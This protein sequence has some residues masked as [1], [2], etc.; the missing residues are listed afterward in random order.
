MGTSLYAGEQLVASGKSVV[1]AGRASSRLDC[2]AVL[3]WSAELPHLYDVVVSLLAIDGSLIEV[4]AVR[5]GFRHIERRDGRFFFN[6]VP[7]TL[8][9]VNRHEFEPDHGRAVTLSS[10]VSDVVT[11]KRHNINAVR[12]SDYPPDRRFLDLC[13]QYGLYVVDEAD[14]ECH[15]FGPVDDQD[16][17]SNDPS[18][19]PAYLDRLERMVARDRNHPSILFWSLGNES[20]CGANHFAMADRAREIDPSRLIHYE[21]CPNAEM[22]DVYS[23][24]YTHPDALAA[25]GEKEH[26]DKPHILCEYGH[27]MGNGPG[28]LQEYWD[29]IERYPR[30]QG[31]FVWEWADHG[32]RFPNGSRPRVFRLRR[33]L[34]RRPQR[35]QFRD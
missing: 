1:E 31:G 5:T 18:W 16:R 26:L 28:S 27:A 19:L 3:P 34:R 17:L 35:F 7:V 25:L 29:V 9:G 24:M 11:M 10:M 15:G 32:L 33:G 2:G 21:R 13:D 23:S 6:G 14:L 4:T 30:L 8:R 12:T 22:A 20:G